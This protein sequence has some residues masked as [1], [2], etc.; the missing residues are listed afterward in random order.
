M[1]E[2]AAI[3]GNAVNAAGQLMTDASPVLIA[4]GARHVTLEGL[5]SRPDVLSEATDEVLIWLFVAGL[6]DGCE[7]CVFLFD[8]PP[9]AEKNK[10]TQDKPL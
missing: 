9:Q 6:V 2:G 4:A 3:L 1:L 7:A 8:D 10:T 5:A